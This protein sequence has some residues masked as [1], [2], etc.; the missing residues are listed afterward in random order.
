MMNRVTAPLSFTPVT[1]DGFGRQSRGVDPERGDEVELLEL[2]R[3]LVAHAEFA[4][5]LGQRVARFASVNHTSYVRL[6]RLDR[7]APDRLVMVS[8]ATP[9]WRLADLLLMA[10]A[11]HVPLPSAAVIAA[12]RQLLPAVTLFSR[13]NR[14]SA[15]GTL[16]PQRLFVTTGARLVIADHAFG[17]AVEKLGLGRERLWHEFRVAMPPSPGL[18][19]ATGR[20]DA[21][22]LGVVALSLA[23]G[24]LLTEDEF[25]ANLAEL[26]QAATDRQL[27]AGSPLTPPFVEW[28]RRALQLDPSTAF[29]SPHEA[30]VAFETFLADDRTQV[31]SSGALETFVTTAGALVQA[32][33]STAPI[34][35]TPAARVVTSPPLTAAPPAVAAVIEAPPVVPPAPPQAPLVP[36]PAPVPTPVA[37]PAVVMAPVPAVAAHATPVTRGWLALTLAVLALLQSG[38]IWFWNRADGPTPSAGEGELVVQSRPTSARVSIDG[39]DR[40]VTPLTLRLSSGTHVLELQTG[41]SEPRVI[42]LTIRAGMQ[43]AQY[44][45]LQNVPVTGAIEVRSDPP[46]AVVLIDGQSRGSTPSIVRDLPPG[47]HEVQLEAAGRKVTQTVRVDAGATTLLVVPMP[48]P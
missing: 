10:E 20:A 47:D 8:D 32:A 16:A 15:I 39:D 41:K 35:P 38:V 43:T 6:R 1:D 33:G 12:L 2:S 40:G 46:G 5:T 21:T 29:Q 9:G 17:P 4:T 19:R 44:V 42:P 45:E 27:A 14:E 25:P 18:P 24:R 30:Q 13:N 3:P 7:P 26:V 48:S 11:R 36:K 31:T 28:I 34:L 37:E 23:L 22:A